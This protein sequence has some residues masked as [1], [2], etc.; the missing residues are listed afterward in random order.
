MVLTDPYSTYEI[1][2]N[3]DFTNDKTSTVTV[4]V[5]SEDEK[6]TNTYTFNVTKVVSTDSSLKEF[7]LG[8]YEFVPEFNK[9]TKEYEVFVPKTLTEEI[10]KVKTTKNTAIIKSITVNS[11]SLT[12][13]SDLEYNSKITGLNPVKEIQ[14]L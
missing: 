13:T 2:G 14:L 12:L 4:K 6:V 9:D 7:K 8:D 10:L 5:K 3:S 11:N 1:T